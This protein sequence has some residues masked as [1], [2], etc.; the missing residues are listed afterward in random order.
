[1][2]ES[3][4]VKRAGT[5][6]ATIDSIVRD[7][8][9]LGVAQG[10]VLLVHSSLSS[11]GW[12]CGHAHAVIVALQEALGPSGTLVMPTQS[13]HLSE[14]SHWQSPPVPSS[15][16]PVIRTAMPPYDER[17][18]PTRGMGV[19]PECFRNQDGAVR[20]RHPQ[21][22][23]A[24]RG[25]KAWEIVSDHAYDYALG[26]QSPL[27]RMYDLDASVLL[28]GV[29]HDRNTSLH[30]AEYRA[31]YPGKMKVQSAAPV[32]IEGERVWRTLADINIR[33]DDFKKLGEA[34]R[35][36]RLI[37]VGMVAQAQAQ[38]F[39]QR[40]AVDFAIEWIESHRR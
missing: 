26:E 29:D 21:V 12:V 32:T 9:A 5:Q 13:A 38:L 1:M 10:S 27:A 39:S 19:I 16:W 8:R 40:A 7:L 15:W 35:K 6:P 34:M 37:N 3:D 33:S 31:E 4:A 18:T 28:L 30:L 24:A 11:M 17:M 25:A 36:A 23:F 20:S 14:P 2:S 22:S